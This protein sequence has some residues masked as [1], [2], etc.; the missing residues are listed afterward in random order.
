MN[1]A[2]RR[3]TLLALLCCIPAC[4]AAAVATTSA[5]RDGIEAH[6]GDLAVRVTALTEDILRI[7]IAPDGRFAEDASWV[8]SSESRSHSVPVQRLNDRQRSGFRTSRLTVELEYAPLRLVVRNSSGAILSADASER[9]V[10]WQG[11]AFTVRKALFASEHVVGLG[12]KAGPLDRRGEEFV[13]WNT[14]AYLYQES[15]DP[16]YKSVPFFISVGAPGGSYGLYLDNTWRSWFDFGKRD[17]GALEFGAAG[18]ALDYYLVYGPSPREVIEGY[19]ALTGRPPLPPLWSLGYQQSRYSYMSADEVRGIASRMRSERIPADVIWL[20]IDYQDRNRP[21]TTNSQTFPDLKQLA[22]DVGLQGIRLVAITDLHI[23]NVPS[24]G[25]QPY[26]TGIAGDH[27]VKRPDGSRYVAEVWPGPALFPDFTRRVT[28]DWWGGLYRDFVASGI[29]GFWND[30]NEP[31]VF[32]TPTRTMPLDIV[33]RIE[34]PGFAARSASHAEV[35]NVYG[36]QNTRATFDG[37]SRLAPNERPYVMTRASFAG[38]QRY[39]VTWTGDNS[40]SWNHLRMVVPMLLNLGLS[41]FAYSG[42]D[43]GGYAGN[44]PPELLTRWIE[45]A[46]FTPVFRAHSAKGSVGKEPWLD[47]AEQTAI[48]RTFIEQ[49]YRLL[50]YIYALADENSRTGVP[51]MRPVFLDYPAATNAPCD[52]SMSFLLGPAL[53]IAPPPQLESPAAYDICLPEGGWYDFWSGTPIV[54][55]RA[56]PAGQTDPSRSQRIAATPALDHLPVFVRAG[57][58]LPRQP[59]VQSTQEMPSGPLIL[60]VFPGEECHGTLY[61]DDGHSQDYRRGAFLR[62]RV[63]CRTTAEG[64]TV[65]FEA[66]E[67]SFAPWWR[68]IEVVVHGWRGPARATV[69]T[70]APAVETNAAAQTARLVV[71]DQPHAAAVVVR[72]AAAMPGPPARVSRAGTG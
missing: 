64:V 54:E 49:R 47:G 15:S 44:P 63:R 9:P 19:T 67:G 1:H 6:D 53:L 16:L 3:A 10:S 35:H 38:G 65:E 37:M 39:A 68:S 17:A 45:I 60:D 25:Y 2:A 36:M 32:G 41:G 46:S 23:A 40:S 56:P 72:H 34:E 50:P 11:A 22:L 18:G 29:A 66:R 69:G 26:E 33:H 61:F 43:V 4:H 27:F 31:A 24:E 70:A 8:V 71:P 28:R 55:N 62:Q 21:F 12:D 20:D 5:L 52:A 59:L 58:V 48:R 57:T 42:A 13:D 14:D 51:L 30:M 7:R